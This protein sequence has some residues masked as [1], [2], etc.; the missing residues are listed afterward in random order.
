MKGQIHFNI[1]D[2][3]YISITP[4]KQTD[5]AWYEY[6]PAITKF[7]GLWTKRR[8]QKPG[9]CKHGGF[10]EYYSSYYGGWEGGRTSDGILKSYS[11]LFFVEENVN[12]KQWFEKARVYIRKKNTDHTRLFETNE[13][14]LAWAEALK[15]KTGDNFEIIIK[16]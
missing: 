11:N 16:E 1:K 15:E 9:W 2:I 13:E 3:E 6:A 10:N 12:G 7:F 14:A 4:V 8:E 5:W